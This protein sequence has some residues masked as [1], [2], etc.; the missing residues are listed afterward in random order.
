MRTLKTNIKL[1]MGL[2]LSVL[3]AG[4]Q[5]IDYYSQAVGGQAQIW[6]A[7][8]DIGVLLSD[9]NIDLQLKRRL[10]NARR[11][12]NFASTELRLP[13]NN[14]YLSFVALDRDYVVWN[15][16]VTPRY[17]VDAVKSCFLIV[18]CVSYRG[19]Y[20]KKAAIEQAEKQK[21]AGFDVYVG[22]VS[23]YS[24]LGWFDDPLLST[25][26]TRSDTAIAGLIFHELAHQKVF[27]KG[28]TKFNESFATAVEQ[29]G[30]SQWARVH[31]INQYN[32]MPSF[33]AYFS[34]KEKRDKIVRLV[35]DAREQ[36][37]R[38]YQENESA[39]ENSL[40]LI[41]REQFS[42]LKKRYA[43]LQKVG[44][45][46]PGFDQFF[47]SHLNNASLALFGEYHGWLDAFEHLYEQSGRDWRVFYAAV[48]ALSLQPEIERDR[49]LRILSSA[50]IE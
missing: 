48:K 26:L 40:A 34:E 19:Y 43:E 33:D 13:E 23:A 41:K 12:R 31:D 39:G 20:K 50:S 46:L 22:G 8:R 36:M 28:D 49:Q 14:S 21:Q 16:I 11:A 7:Q 15:V 38:A 2:I 37:R 29:I 25:M 45:G 1:S 42:M 47:E 9:P 35:L 30:L 32:V 6:R 5:S 24:T 27:I 17:S 18:G 4:C 44:G 10:R 3:L